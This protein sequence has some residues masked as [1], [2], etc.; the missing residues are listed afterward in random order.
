L[1]VLV[2]EGF[3]DGGELLLLTP[4]EVRGGFEELLHLAGWI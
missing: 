4:G 2:D 1:G 3:E